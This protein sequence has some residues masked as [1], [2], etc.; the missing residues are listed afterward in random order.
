M[1]PAQHPIQNPNINFYNNM[2]YQGYNNNSNNQGYNNNNNNANYSYMGDNYY[3]ANEPNFN[4]MKNQK[5][6][7]Q[8]NYQGN[9]QYNQDFNNNQNLMMKNKMN[10]KID[11]QMN[12][13][14]YGGMNPQMLKNPPNMMGQNMNNN[15]P[16]NMQNFPKNRMNNNNKMWN[17]TQ[18]NKHE[19]MK[20]MSYGDKVIKKIKPNEKMVIE[21]KANLLENYD[22][23]SK[24][25]NEE[26]LQ[27]SPS[28]SKSS[29]VKILFQ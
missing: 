12:M 29:D 25:D 26:E 6:V 19:E 1:Y 22:E 2:G 3:N 10:K 28:K 15:G 5:F 18:N 21:N 17:N 23:L 27:F 14:K 9:Y 7:D 13:G 20:E 16:N 11:M 8:R 4:N 24:E